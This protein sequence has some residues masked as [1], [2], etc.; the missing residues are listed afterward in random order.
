MVFADGAGALAPVQK[1]SLQ[2][3]NQGTC[4]AASIKPYGNFWKAAGQKTSLQDIYQA[5]NQKN[6]HRHLLPKLEARWRQSSI[7]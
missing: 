6:R 2:A 7:K 1:V 5:V 4:Y 3:A